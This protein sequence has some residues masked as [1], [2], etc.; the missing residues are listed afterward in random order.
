MKREN[1]L[2]IFN[3]IDMNSFS[4]IWL[5]H[6]VRNG[7]KKKKSSEF[8]FE[9]IHLDDFDEN[10]VP[11][12]SLILVHHHRLVAFNCLNKFL[13]FIISNKSLADDKNENC[14]FLCEAQKKI[15]N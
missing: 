11:L 13:S 15:D 9:L 2:L 5:G 10:I 6:K 3:Y 1:L 8:V 4:I 12:H 7:M 14:Y